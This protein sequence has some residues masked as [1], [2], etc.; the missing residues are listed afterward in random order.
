MRR[1]ITQNDYDR[2][3]SAQSPILSPT[4]DWAAWTEVPQVGDAELL[5]R[6]TRGT[7]SARI[8]RGFIG[9]PI[10]N[11]T[12]V[13]DSPFVAPA[14]Q[15]TARR[16][17]AGRASGT[18]RWRSSSVRAKPGRG[19]LPAPRNSLIIVP[20]TGAS[21]LQPVI[22][23]RVRNVRVLARRRPHASPT[24]SK[25]DSAATRGAGDSA[26]RRSTGDTSTRRARPR[27]FGT[28][29][30]ASQRRHGRRGTDCGREL[31]RALDPDGTYLAYTVVSRDAGRAGAL[32]PVD[33]RRHR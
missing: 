17:D 16:L 9:R 24:S 12:A 13:T 26:S 33:R 7:R 15:F 8:P 22:V 23:P 2:W 20:L 14:P 27:E 4:G 3:R 25:P 18:R 6:E 29:A 28:H 1:A 21:A 11:L 32:L 5:V 10:V 30:G 31:L 19:A